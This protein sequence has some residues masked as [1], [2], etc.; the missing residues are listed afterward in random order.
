MRFLRV[1]AVFPAGVY[2]DGFFFFCSLLLQR[3]GLES[4]GNSL[5]KVYRTPQSIQDFFETRYAP[6]SDLVGLQPT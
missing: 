3:P 1:R 6:S 5:V 4:R 2:E